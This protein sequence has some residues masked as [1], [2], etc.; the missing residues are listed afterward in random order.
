MKPSFSIYDFLLIIV[1]QKRGD[2][3]EAEA[4]PP[5]P[6]LLQPAHLLFIPSHAFVGPTCLFLL[7]TARTIT[8]ALEMK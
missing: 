6:P 4:I 3:A 1:Q 8:R 7:P 2:E 5:S